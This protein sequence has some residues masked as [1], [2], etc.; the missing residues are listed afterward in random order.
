MA[1]EEPNGS[2][3]WQLRVVEYLK[4]LVKDHDCPADSWTLRGLVQDFHL[5]VRVNCKP[6]VRLSGSFITWLKVDLRD[7][8]LCILYGASRSPIHHLK[9][10][11]ILGRDTQTEEVVGVTLGL[12]NEYSLSPRDL[13]CELDDWVNLKILPMKVVMK[14]VKKGKH[15]P[16][17]IG[18]YR[19]SKRIGNVAYELEQPLDLAKGLLGELKWFSSASHVEG[20]GYGHDST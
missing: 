7:F 9:P 16:R 5:E 12:I 17:Y 14:F 10:K 1:R 20:V 6:G 13:E 4:P 8:K 15:S 19:I 18:P 3:W 11:G 2:W